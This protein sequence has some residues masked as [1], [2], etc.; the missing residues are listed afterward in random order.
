VPLM[1]ESFDLLIDRRAYFEP[2]MQ[3]LMTFC[4]GTELQSYAAK[5]GGYDLSEIGQIRWNSG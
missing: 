4:R 2:P 3:A 5:L 1:D